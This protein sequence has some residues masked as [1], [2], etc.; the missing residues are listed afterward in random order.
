MEKNCLIFQF[1]WSARPGAMY[2]FIKVCQTKVGWWNLSQKYKRSHN[3]QYH[4]E[5][6]TAVECPKIK[7]LINAEVIS[8]RESWEAFQTGDNVTV[9]CYP[10][11]VFI[12]TDMEKGQNEVK[13]TCLED[14]TWTGYD[15][16]HCYSK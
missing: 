8:S 2:C 6:V 7:N 9:Q 11:H 3:L 10:D 15:E 16:Y 5:T 1:L 13:R 4:V 14:G 12:G